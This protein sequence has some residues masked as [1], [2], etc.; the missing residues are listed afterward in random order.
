M[1]DILAIILKNTYS[2]AQFKHRVRILKS[3]LLKA[4]FG[5]NEANAA[6]PPSDLNWLKS[7]SAQVYHKF[8]KDNVYQII[9]GLEEQC[10]KLPTLTMYL[11]F[12]PDEATLGQIGSFA[13]QAFGPMLLLDIRFDPNLIAGTALSWKGVYKD[14]SLKARME[15]KK[16]EILEGFKKFLR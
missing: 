9:S 16:A 14:Y 15:E 4:F 7:L 2:L 12:E 13:R 8:N 10:T 3:A 5:S 1:G 6:L 11:T